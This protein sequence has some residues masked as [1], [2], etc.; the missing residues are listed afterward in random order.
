MVAVHLFGLAAPLDRAALRADAEPGP[1]H[2]G[3]RD[4]HRRGIGCL[5][6]EVHFAEGHLVQELEAERELWLVNHVG[7]AHGVGRAVDQRLANVEPALPLVRVVGNATVA[8]QRSCEDRRELQ[9]LTHSTAIAPHRVAAAWAVGVVVAGRKWLGVRALPAEPPRLGLDLGNVHLVHHHPSPF[10]VEGVV[11][12]QL[13]D[14]RG[15]WAL[16]FEGQRIRC[17]SAGFGFAHDDRTQQHTL[18]RERIVRQQAL[19]GQHVQRR[20]AL[21]AADQA[22]KRRS[23]L[24]QAHQLGLV[25]LATHGQGLE[26]FNLLLRALGLPL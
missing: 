15:T 25:F 16:V 3:T 18:L 13:G 11:G 20:L 8:V 22:R 7:I 14:G 5:L 19:V 24:H 10:G 1:V 4:G 23:L 21:D 6:T 9:H 26:L 12:R 2:L 17:P